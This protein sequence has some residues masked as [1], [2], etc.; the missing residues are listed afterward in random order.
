M[1]AWAYLG[2]DAAVSD[3]CERAFGPAA[4]RLELSPGLK[5]AARALRQAYIDYVGQLNRT[6]HAAVGWWSSTLAEKNP[7]VSDT[8]FFSCCVLACREIVGQGGH[9]DAVLLVVENASLRRA[10]ARNLAGAAADVRVVAGWASTLA[11]VAGQTARMAVRKAYWLGVN[12]ARVFHARHRLRLHRTPGIIEAARS[13]TPVCL[14]HTW[15]D[16]RAYDQT[17]GRFWDQDFGEVRRHLENKGRRVFTVP[18]IL[19]A[20]SFSRV[21]GYVASDPDG[22]VVPEAFLRLRDVVAVLVRASLHVPRR[23]RYPPLAGL[24]ISDLIY[25]DEWNDW[26]SPRT[27]VHLLAARWVLRWKQS[28]LR[29]ERFIYTFENHAWERRVCDAFRRFYPEARL[30]AHQPNGLPLL[31]MNYFIA[32]AERD[33]V[34]LPDLIITNGCYAARVLKAS[35]YDPDRVVCG[36]G[37]RQRYLQ[38]WFDGAQPRAQA[39]KG[40]KRVVVTPSIGHAETLELLKKAIAAFAAARDLSVIIKCHPSMPFEKIAPALGGV[41]LPPHITVSKE[42]LKV[43]LQA[44]DVLVYNGGAFPSVEALAAGVPVVHVEPEFALDLDPLDACPELG[45]D[46]RSPEEIL[47]CVRERLSEGPAKAVETLER[48][49]RVL[50]ELIGKVDEATYELF[51]G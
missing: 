5:A 37:L 3:R 17:T 41:A 34:P 26:V 8:F 29:I 22:Y 19:W 15:V 40:T 51:R 7:Y 32:T 45:L 6:R 48:S 9:G 30:I 35:G 14:I 4:K 28:G 46:A 18:N 33:I 36:G 24:D 12:L 20:V 44:A 50:G 39:R 11:A 42:P 13:R 23:R 47:A 31:L 27:A 16:E 10:L 1:F 38:D 25:E 43:L 2:Q 21:L 49:R